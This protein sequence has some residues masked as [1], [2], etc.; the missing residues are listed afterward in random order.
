MGF[1]FWAQRSCR[2]HQHYTTPL[3]KPRN[4]YWNRLFKQSHQA[5][6]T[7][8][9]QGRKRRLAEFSWVIIQCRGQRSW[10]APGAFQSGELRPQN[11]YRYWLTPWTWNDATQVLWTLSTL[12]STTFKE[13]GIYCVHVNWGILWLLDPQ[14]QPGICLV[15]VRNIGVDWSYKA[16]LVDSCL[17]VRDVLAPWESSAA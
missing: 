7:S 4:I 15:V 1:Q 10:Q 2:T 9:L 8:F 12:T 11:E 17:L 5:T 14:H 16:V 13:S 3:D 6:I